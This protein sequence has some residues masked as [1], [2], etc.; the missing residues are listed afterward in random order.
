MKAF[1]IGDKSLSDRLLGNS[2]VQGALFRMMNRLPDLIAFGMGAG[3][4]KALIEGNLGVG[5]EHGFVL[6]A[7]GTAMVGVLGALDK[8][9]RAAVDITEQN[10]SSAAAASVAAAD[11]HQGETIQPQG[12]SKLRFKM[13]SKNP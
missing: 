5:M 10:S 12:T 9:S 2:H 1:L 11:T 3:T 8:T 13:G 6:F 7:S 4:A